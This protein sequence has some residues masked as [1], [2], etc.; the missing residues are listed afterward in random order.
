MIYDQLK[1]LK[2][3]ILGILFIVRTGKTYQEYINLSDSV[4]RTAF[5]V[6][7]F[8]RDWMKYRDRISDVDS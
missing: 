6:E 2:K 7:H 8:G 1:K 5:L 3:R 4:E